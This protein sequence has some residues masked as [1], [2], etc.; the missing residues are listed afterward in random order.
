MRSRLSVFLFVSS[1]LGFIAAILD[2]GQILI[3]GSSGIANGLRL[4]DVNGFIQAREVLLSISAGTVF[5]FYWT[6]VGRR[7]FGSISSQPLFP[8]TRTT[9]MASLHC[10]RWERWGYIGFGLQ[11]LTIL[12]CVL[13]PILQIVWR[14]DPKHHQ[15]DDLYVAASVFETTISII[16]ILKI[17]LNLSL[18]SLE[19]RR[20]VFVD[21]TAPI[22]AL[23]TSTG[24]GIG[25]LVLCKGPIQSKV[26]VHSPF[27]IVAFSE[28]TLGR[29]LRAIE[30]YILLVWFLIVTFRHAKA[31]EE[32]LRHKDNSSVEKATLPYFEPVTHLSQGRTATTT[33]TTRQGGAT[34]LK[35]WGPTRDSAVSKVGSWISNGRFNR[36]FSS[37]REGLRD[38][39]A[40]LSPSPEPSVLFRTA[41]ELT[42]EKQPADVGREELLKPPALAVAPTGEGDRPYTEISLSYYAMV[43]DLRPP[44]KSVTIQD[45]YS[46]GSDSP[47]YGLDGI[48]PPRRPKPAPESIVVQPPT[49]RSAATSAILSPIDQLMQQQSDLDK[50][51]SKLR[52]L[53]NRQNSV[54]APASLNVNRESRNGQVVDVP[55]RESTQRNTI[56][57]T[58]S[59]SSFSKPFS[60]A[61][62]RS[63]FTLSN[64]PDPPE[65]KAPAP[66][67]RPGPKVGIVPIQIPPL[68]ISSNPASPFFGLT[69]TR[70]DS[71]G[72]Q[73]DV[74]S[75]I[76]GPYTYTFIEGVATDLVCRFRWSRK[77]LH[78]R[79]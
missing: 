21:Y 41:P 15:Y 68:D 22:C 40:A 49:A 26:D 69:G 53:H 44:S 48:V 6:L 64:F 76:G 61:S 12:I 8:N 38:N 50:S 59:F 34:F 19:E 39:E 29:F 72:T 67:A 25:N 58:P 1:F 10:G 46:I 4:A 37:S 35:P 54:P 23:A 63:E 9:R 3:R 11:W 14:V 24:H 52:G 43:G 70:F 13:I 47:V 73:F 5:I 42:S 78:H 30:V 55:S 32:D 57:V 74:T 2:L 16:F 60:S 18:T 36:L 79:R 31:T 71:A 75:F 62:E 33:G 7:P 27:L 77:R 45:T 65:G 20:Q 66:T 28:T 17:F 56:L 51:I